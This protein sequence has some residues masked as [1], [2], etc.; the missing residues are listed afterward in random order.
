MLPAVFHFT[1][2]N[3]NSY[4]KQNQIIRANSAFTEY[5]SYAKND[6]QLMATKNFFKKRKHSKTSANLMISVTG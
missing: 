3:V 4:G 6:K 5:C 2:K 1:L